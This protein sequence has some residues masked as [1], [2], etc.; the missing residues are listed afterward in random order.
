[1]KLPVNLIIAM[2]LALAPIPAAHA[3]AVGQSTD[4]PPTLPP[5]ESVNASALEALPDQFPP[6]PPSSRGMAP[7]E[8]SPLNGN[9]K[10]DVLLSPPNADSGELG[11]LSLPVDIMPEVR[12]HRQDA[13]KIN[14]TPGHK[15]E[16]IILDL[17]KPDYATHHLPPPANNDA[18]EPGVLS[19][20]VTIM[21]EVR[22]HRQDAIKI[23]ATPGH[24]KDAIAIKPEKST[25]AESHISLP[26]LPP[27][28]EQPPVLISMAN[29]HECDKHLNDYLSFWETT[30]KKQTNLSDS[31]QSSLFH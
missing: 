1:M 23:N 15:N 2:A 24:K 5:R 22:Q 10:G 20:P 3:V 11:T 19:A 6:P 25:T 12:Q 4:K 17:K 29:A 26:G 7:S 16:V 18:S 21:P 28:R 31:D 9:S 14:V 30:V 27:E 13:I 8:L